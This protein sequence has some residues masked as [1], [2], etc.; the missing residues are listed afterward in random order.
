M[1]MLYHNTVTDRRLHSKDWLQATHS[2][3]VYT[4]PMGIRRSTTI[5]I[6]IS[7]VESITTPSRRPPFGL[8]V[9]SLHPL[10][11]RLH[12]RTKTLYSI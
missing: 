8:G 5:L 4:L 7:L 6:R 2:C 11:R 3:F 12:G 9:R 1:P 10:S